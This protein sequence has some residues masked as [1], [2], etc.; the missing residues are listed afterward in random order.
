M[1]GGTDRVSGPVPPIAG[2]SGDR[3]MDVQCQRRMP[4]WFRSG[5][6]GGCEGGLLL[7]CTPAG[8]AVAGCSSE[9]PRRMKGVERWVRTGHGR[10]KVAPRCS[11]GQQLRSKTFAGRSFASRKRSKT[12][13]GSSFV[14]QQ[15]S[16]FFA[17]SS[18]ASQLWSAG[19]EVCS[20]GQ[21][22][23][24]IISQR[25]SAVGGL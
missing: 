21:Q 18:F 20:K 5:G 10:S 4:W 16:F 15:R 23:R 11:A 19:V 1:A 2:S 12:F 6:S 3:W 24:S 7:R 8:H 22:L 9:V 25:R 13:T 14:S 17:G